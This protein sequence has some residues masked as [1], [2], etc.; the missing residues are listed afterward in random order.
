[1]HQ[2][3]DFIKRNFDFVKRSDP[4]NSGLRLTREMIFS[5]FLHYIHT[6]NLYLIIIK[7]LHFYF[8]AT[9]AIMLSCTTD[10]QLCF[11][12]RP[13]TFNGTFQNHHTTK[14]YSVICHK[15]ISTQFTLL[16]ASYTHPNPIKHFCNISCNIYDRIRLLPNFEHIFSNFD[17]RPT[18]G[19]KII[20]QQPSLCKR[21]LQRM[22]L[23][24]KAN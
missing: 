21:P 10:V 15:N 19:L 17:Y 18:L 16:L 9:H 22:L 2:N 24:C 6:A 20:P 8:S 11:A 1:M 23:Q 3:F 12:N 5:L 14:V 7:T 13:V 4:G